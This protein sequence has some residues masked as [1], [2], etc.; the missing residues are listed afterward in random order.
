MPSRPGE[1]LAA[2]DPKLGRIEVVV[3]SR[4]VLLRG[5]GLLTGSMLLGCGQGPMERVAPAA[6]VLPGATHIPAP[7]ETPGPFDAEMAVVRPGTFQMGE[8]GNAGGD[9]PLHAVTITRAYAL[10]VQLVTFE[11]Y[12]R[13]CQAVGSSSPEDEGRGRGQRPVIHVDWNAAVAYCRWLSEQ[14]GLAD[15]YQGKGKV[16]TCDFRLPGFRLPSEAEWEYAARGGHLRQDTLYAGSDDL[17]AVGWY[18]DNSDGATHPVGLLAANALGIHDLC[19]NV[20]EW[21]W[22][23]YLRDYYP[24]SPTSDPTGPD[25]GQ[26]NRYLGGWERV[27]RGGAFNEEAPSCTVGYRSFDGQA[28]SAFASGFRVAR[29]LCEDELG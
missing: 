15:C 14:A 11:A 12:D 4:R 8:A 26:E 21:C 3:C 5:L 2:A 1:A 10:G 24:Q 7:T 28:Y 20:W 27:R 22:D 18:A 19:G 17:A 6:V 16:I 9:A 23:K 29:T 25:R 13:Y